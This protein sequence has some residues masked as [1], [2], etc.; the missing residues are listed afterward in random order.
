MRTIGK[1]IHRMDGACKVSGQATYIDDIFMPGMLHA[2]ILRSTIASGFV[3]SIDTVEAAALP[4]VEAVIT[5]KDVPAHTFPTAGHPYH[6]DPAHRDVADRNLLTG[7]IRLW[8]DEIAAVV[9]VDELTAEKA[10]K[11]IKVEYEECTPI[12][13]GEQALQPGAPEIHAGTGNL[14]K[15]TSF[16]DGNLEVSMTE[17]DYILEDQFKTNVVQHCAMENHSALAYVD[18]SGSITTSCLLPKPPPIYGLITLILL[19]GIP[20]A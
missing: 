20:S 10:V 7:R 12:L 11:L 3:T 4:G 9:A 14:I 1:S 16:S 2:K 5:F 15:R 13:S 6:L 18:A 19:Q 17:A 8:G